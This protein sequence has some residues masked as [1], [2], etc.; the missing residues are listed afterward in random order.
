M[1]SL[2]TNKFTVSNIYVVVLTIFIWIEA[3]VF[4][5]YKWF[6]TWHLNKSG[7]Y[8]DPSIYYYCSPVQGRM[9]G[10]STSVYEF[11]RGWLEANTFINVYGWQNM[12][13]HYV[14]RQRT[15]WVHCK[16]S[17]IAISERR[18]HISRQISRICSFSL[19]FTKF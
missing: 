1:A 10:V 17:T 11:N 19:I 2:E 12:Q 18:M 4:I 15:W 8:S 3:R 6:L 9:A 14:G 13:V 7:I 5:S 16:W